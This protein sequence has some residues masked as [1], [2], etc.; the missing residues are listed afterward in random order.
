MTFST[1][2]FQ[3]G[4][5]RALPMALGVFAYAATFGLLARE[6]GIS[7]LESALMSATMFSGSAQTA[8]VGGLAHG[9]GVFASMVTVI[10]IN[11]RYLLYGAALRPWLG[12]ATPRQA[13]GS[14]YFLGDGSWVLALKARAD[15]EEDAAFILGSGFAMFAPWVLGTLIGWHAGSWIADPRVLALDFLLAAF[16]AA[17]AVG[18][19][20]SKSDWVTIALALACALLLDAFAPSGWT[21]VVTGIVGAISGYLRHQD[22]PVAAV[23][24]TTP[25]APS[26]PRPP[27]A[28]DGD[29]A[30]R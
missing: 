2:G 8:T 7:A 21:I 3:R 26:S 10:M 24:S 13:Y 23:A 1:A 20:R 18:L 15:G 16:C 29:D 6:A 17:M 27:T 9:A 25:Q 11:A 5:A 22:A 12:G 19:Y 28:K 30:A 4:F 14:L